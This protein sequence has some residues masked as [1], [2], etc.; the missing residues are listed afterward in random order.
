MSNSIF[1]AISKRCLLH[2]AVISIRLIVL[3]HRCAMH[4]AVGTKS[5]HATPFLPVVIIRHRT[6]QVSL[7]CPSIWSTTLEDTIKYYFDPTSK[8]PSRPS[9]R[10]SD[11]Q[12]QSNRSG[13][14][15]EAP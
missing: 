6:D 3:L 4:A 12:Q 10:E 7:W 2:V 15:Q 1:Y 8:V 13:T 14:K 5:W 9:T 11:V